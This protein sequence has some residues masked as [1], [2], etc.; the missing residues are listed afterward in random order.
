[1]LFIMFVGEKF[2]TS[3]CCG[4]SR[5][6]MSDSKYW[7]SGRSR[8]L[9]MVRSFLLL[10]WV[11][12]L[13]IIC[14]W[15]LFTLDCSDWPATLLPLVVESL[16]SAKAI[17]CPASLLFWLPVTLVGPSCWLWWCNFWLSVTWSSHSTNWKFFTLA[18]VTRPWKFN[19]YDWLSTWATN[20]YWQ[21]RYGPLEKV[22]QQSM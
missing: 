4:S 5:F 17:G 19:T 13:A 22:R 15:N 2:E 6:V 21:R 10:C 8:L 9:F 11:W 7:S 3:D 14:D 18:C 20:L 1:M 12:P 16:L